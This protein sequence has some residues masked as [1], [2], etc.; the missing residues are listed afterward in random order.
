LWRYLTDEI[1]NTVAV[2]AGQIYGLITGASRRRRRRRHEFASAADN[3]ALK[4]EQNLIH[5][6]CVKTV[7]YGKI[8]GHSLYISGVE[9]VACATVVD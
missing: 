3:F 7:K 9:K 1:S 5:A 8:L 4:N 6:T 2:G